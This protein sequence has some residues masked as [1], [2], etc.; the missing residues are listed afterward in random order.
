[1]ESKGM[2]QDLISELH[3]QRG[4]VYMHFKVELSLD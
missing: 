4:T 2:T 3:P 1:M